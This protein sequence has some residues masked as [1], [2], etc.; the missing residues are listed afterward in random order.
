[1]QALKDLMGSCC[2][3]G[4]HLPWGPIPQCLYRALP[5]NQGL[6]PGG[7][8]AYFTGSQYF[9]WVLLYSP[10]AGPQEIGQGHLAAVMA[11]Q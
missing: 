2:C 7:P 6:Q 9:S 4:S 1:M 10:P 5:T 8:Q 11:E 3:G